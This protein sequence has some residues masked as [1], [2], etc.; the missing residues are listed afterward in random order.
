MFR[1]KITLKQLFF[2]Y[3]CTIK[4]FIV[5]QPI[6]VRLPGIGLTM[7]RLE[8]QFLRGPS[9]VGSFTHIINCLDVCRFHHNGILDRTARDKF[10]FKLRV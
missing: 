9:A 6:Y 10:R 3:V 8:L 7:R 1:T 4:Q 2:I 5:I